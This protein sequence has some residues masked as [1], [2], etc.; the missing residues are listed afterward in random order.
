MLDMCL[1]FEC[2]SVGGCGVSEAWVGGL[3]QGLE[4]WCGVI[5]V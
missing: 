3:D 4:G 5:F 1:C 2:R